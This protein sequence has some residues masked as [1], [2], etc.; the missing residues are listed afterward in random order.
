MSG[1]HAAIAR[2]RREQSLR[3]D[4]GAPRPDLIGRAAPLPQRPVSPARRSEAY[5]AR[6][7]HRQSY[8]FRCFGSSAAAIRAVGPLDS[9]SAARQARQDLLPVAPARSQESLN[10]I[11][12]LEQEEI[13]RLG[14]TIPVFAPGDTVIV[15]VNVVEGSASASR[16]TKAW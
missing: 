14:K 6:G 2:W 3:A 7:D 12:T 1:H 9:R 5:L 16:P 11:Q 10:L 8:N 15:N 13:A 4:A